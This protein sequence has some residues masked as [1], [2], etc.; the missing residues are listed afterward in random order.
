MLL[1]EMLMSPLR[2]QMDEDIVVRGM[3]TRTRESYLYVVAALAKHYGRRPDKIS[4]SE[5]QRYPMLATRSSRLSSTCHELREFKRLEARKI[6]ILR[7]QGD[8][9]AKVTRLAYAT[10]LRRNRRPRWRPT[11]RVARRCSRVPEH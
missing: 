11:A 4:E 1:Q 10:R 6:I 2:K 9:R 5:V 3:S 8:H 7:S